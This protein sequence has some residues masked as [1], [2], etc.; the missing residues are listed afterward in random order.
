MLSTVL[1]IDDDPIHRALL[2]RIVM[3]LGYEVRL[4][5]SGED[6]L[7]LLAGSEASGSKPFFSIWSCQ[8]LTGWACCIGLGRLDR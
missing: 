4:A 3:R 8:T 5:F 7:T 1:V 2:E 6:A